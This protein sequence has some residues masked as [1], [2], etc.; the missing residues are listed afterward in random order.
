[1]VSFTYGLKSAESRRQYPRRFKVFLDFLNFKGDLS[2]QAKKFWLMAKDNPR[3]AEEKKLDIR[4]TILSELHKISIDSTK[5]L[6]K[7]KEEVLEEKKR[8]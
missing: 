8:K 6:N 7:L 1:M 5:S 3:W 4:Y 2:N